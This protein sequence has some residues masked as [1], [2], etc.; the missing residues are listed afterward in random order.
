MKGMKALEYRIWAKSFIKYKG[1]LDELNK[2]RILIRKIR[3]IRLDINSSI[4]NDQFKDE[5]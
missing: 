4:N 1:N 2:I 3:L 5:F